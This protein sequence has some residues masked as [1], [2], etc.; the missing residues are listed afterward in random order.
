M[1]RSVIIPTV[2]PSWTTG[3]V[4]HLPAAIRVAA[5]PR[6]VSDV[7]QSAW[8][9]IACETCMARILGRGAAGL[10]MHLRHSRDGRPVTASSR[11]RANARHT[12]TDLQEQELRVLLPARPKDDL[13]DVSRL[14]NAVMPS[15]R[16]HVHR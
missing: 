16:T 4:P 5:A 15:S 8:A 6:V 10:L 2:L 9:V 14:L 13:G 12:M 1:S 11:R 7:Q 3:S